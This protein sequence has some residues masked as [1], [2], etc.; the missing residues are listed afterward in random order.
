VTEDALQVALNN[1][2]LTLEA[3]SRSYGK[4]W[5]GRLGYGLGLRV[6]NVMGWFF[7]KFRLSVSGVDWGEYRRTVVQNTDFRKFDDVLRQVLSGDS[8]QRTELE[9]YLQAGFARGELAYGIHCSASALLTCLIA[10]RSGEHFHFVDGADGGYAV[11][12]VDLK[13]R[14][15]ELSDR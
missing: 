9:A 4:N 10:S 5:F 11:A 8:S 12:A 3:R 7:M 2:T 1:N 6:K 15:R 14:L 13:R